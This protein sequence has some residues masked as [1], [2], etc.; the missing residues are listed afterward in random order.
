MRADRTCYY[1]G[2][3]GCILGGGGGEGMALVRN[4][5]AFVQI[6]FATCS[7]DCIIPIDNFLFLW[8]A[9][10]RIESLY[11]SSA[12]LC[13]FISLVTPGYHLQLPETF[14]CLHQTRLL[15]IKTKT[16]SRD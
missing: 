3:E 4:H 14:F 1:D 6:S 10:R 9:A 13:S 8:F 7:F 11:I 5:E 12:R 2:R 15:K 16:K